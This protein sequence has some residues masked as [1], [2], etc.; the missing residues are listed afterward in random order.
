M[1]R[2]TP[3]HRPSSRRQRGFT[4]IEVMIVVAILA[5]L[6]ALALPA[7][8]DSVT[9]TWRNKA[10]ACLTELAQR[11]ERRFTGNMSYVGPAGAAD[12]LPPNSCT[13]EDG[14]ADRYAF[15]FT[16]D[17]TARAFTLQAVPQ[18]VQAARDTGC[19]TLRIDQSGVRTVTGETPVERCW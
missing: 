13:T 8:Q 1:T 2:F 10:S 17:P 3:A 5:I 14:M 7:Y 19:A 16:A 18:N 11:M 4:L 9:K 12:E 6:V 15:S